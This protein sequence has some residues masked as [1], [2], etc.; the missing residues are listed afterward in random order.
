MFDG[1]NCSEKFRKALGKV[2]VME[3]FCSKSIHLKPEI[4]IKMDSNTLIPAFKNLL[5]YS[6]ILAFSLVQPSS[7]QFGMPQKML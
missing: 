6:L 1:K 4:Q 5:V 2:S 3:P 7:Y